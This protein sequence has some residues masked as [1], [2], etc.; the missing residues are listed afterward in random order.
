MGDD[1]PPYSAQ[2]TNSHTLL[3]PRPPANPEVTRTRPAANSARLF[4]D[5][6]SLVHPLAPKI[7]TLPPPRQRP[8]PAPEY[9]RNRNAP[10]NPDH[11]LPIP[12]PPRPPA[13]PPPTPRLYSSSFPFALPYP[14]P[15]PNTRQYAPA[16]AIRPLTLLHTP[17]LPPHPPHPAAPPH[18]RVTPPKPP[19]NL[20]RILVRDAN[21]LTPPS[22]PPRT[23]PPNL[24]I[25]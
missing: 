17:P 24:S 10:T 8:P 13:L 6:I 11:R 21:R 22:A 3:T 9:S 4:L 16:V 2:P 19:S 7:L 1:L 23:S 20:P 12:S 14:F 25:Q 15:P 18:T 5:H